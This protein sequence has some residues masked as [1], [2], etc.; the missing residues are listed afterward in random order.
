MPNTQ[1][2]LLLVRPCYRLLKKA[3]MSSTSDEGDKGGTNTTSG[4]GKPSAQSRPDSNPS[5]HY[6][7][8]QIPDNKFSEFAEKTGLTQKMGSTQKTSE[9]FA[10]T[11]RGSF[12]MVQPPD[13]AGMRTV[14]VLHSHRTRR[15]L[16]HRRDTDAALPKNGEIGKSR[17]ERERGEYRPVAALGTSRPHQAIA[18]HYG[19]SQGSGFSALDKPKTYESG[20]FNQSEEKWTEKH[21]PGAKEDGAPN[22]MTQ[23]H[24][25][26]RYAK[27]MLGVKNAMSPAMLLGGNDMCKNC[28]EGL[29]T[30]VAGPEDRP[31]AYTGYKPFGS[32]DE[33]NHKNNKD[34]QYIALDNSSITRSRPEEMMGEAHKKDHTDWA[35]DIEKLRTNTH[36]Y[37]VG[38]AAQTS[39]SASASA[40]P[41]SGRGGTPPP[42]AFGPPIDPG[43]HPSP[44]DMGAPSRTGN[45]GTAGRS[46]RTAPENSTSASK[47]GSVKS[48]TRAAI[49]S[50]AGTTRESSTG[51]AIGSSTKAPSRAIAPA[52]TAT[53]T[54]GPRRDTRE[55]FMARTRSASRSEPETKR[56]RTES[57][58]AQKR[59]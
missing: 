58:P 16:E 41:T 14:D 52:A 13:D 37:Q 31:V 4:G 22:P 27:A 35:D 49:E 32:Q 51:T 48:S 1:E 7:R 56:L 3:I 21:W 38:D 47:R 57:K 26:T 25:E 17:L 20:G 45:S 54:S 9:N 50:S 59:K 53:G 11:R 43:T 5:K 40:S 55:R 15:Q 44:S 46:N 10:R 24:S 36:S 6:S 39:D 8:F 29:R 28:Q 12:V 33:W 34:K 18:E 19:W 30:T 23:H 42:S 2:Q